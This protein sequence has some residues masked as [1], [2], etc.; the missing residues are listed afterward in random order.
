MGISE[1]FRLYCKVF[2]FFFYDLL[3][4]LFISYFQAVATK[5]SCK[6]KTF[7]KNGVWDF[8]CKWDHKARECVKGGAP[9]IAPSDS[10]KKS[11]KNKKNKK[12]KN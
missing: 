9:Q 7:Q 10:P 2:T 8:S 6:C 11:K 1:V 3:Y 12:Q 5:A 4:L